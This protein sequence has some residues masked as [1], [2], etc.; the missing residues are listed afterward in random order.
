VEDV[1]PDPVVEVIPQHQRSVP[2]ALPS[3]PH[4]QQQYSQHHPKYQQQQQLHQ[5]Q[6]LNQQQD[7]HQSHQR[8][9]EIKTCSSR[10][11]PPNSD[12]SQNTRSSTNSTLVYC[13]QPNVLGNTRFC[14]ICFMSTFIHNCEPFVM[15]VQL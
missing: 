2:T 14:T 13:S 5:Q 6:Q 1:Q 7:Y 12:S 11:G 15:S 8:Q 10:T 4:H 3:P 9:T